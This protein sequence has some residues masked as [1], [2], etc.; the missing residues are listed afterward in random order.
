MKTS[1]RSRSAY[2]PKFPRLKRLMSRRRLGHQPQD[3]GFTP[4][5]SDDT[6]TH[7]TNKALT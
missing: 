4:A 7:P 5:D 2:H 6:S 3:Q 1:E